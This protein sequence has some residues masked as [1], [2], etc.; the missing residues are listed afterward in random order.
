MKLVSVIIP[1]YKVEKYLARCLD[2][3]IAQDYPKTEIIVVD[4]GSPD[5]C[6]AICDNYKK[7]YGNIVVIHKKNG[8]LSDARN[9]GIEKANGDYLT[10]VD[11]DDSID[12]DYVSFLVKTLEN[13]NADISVCGYTSIYKNK[14]ISHSSTKRMELSQ[15]EALEKIL[16]Q[17]DFD[18]M[19]CAKLYKKKLFKDVR[20]P[21]GEKYEDSSTT[22]KLIMNSKKVACDL[23]SKY[24]YFIRNDSIVTTK[25]SADDCMLIESYDRMTKD[26]ENKFPNL[27]AACQRARSY[28]RLSVLRQI[29]ESNVNEKILEKKLRKEVLSLATSNLK[30]K[31]VKKLDK[32]AIIV[33]FFGRRCFKYSWRLYK[34]MSG[35]RI[36]G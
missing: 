35:R 13:A 15:E 12:S 18:V 3:V 32:I 29:A 5:N 34:K 24:N 7:K 20:F 1:V 36:S 10:F 9:A 2:S 21:K 16:Y 28:S 30:N 22:Y 8:G 11:S 27:C 17:E 6:P 33:L 25:F 26:T 23:E 4:D 14:Q 31:R 19:A